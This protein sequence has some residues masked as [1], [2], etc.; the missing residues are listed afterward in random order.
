MAIKIQC[1]TESDNAAFFGDD[2]D[3]QHQLPAP[4]YDEPKARTG[5]P[6]VVIDN[7][8]V[9]AWLI[10]TGCLS[11]TQLVEAY[12]WADDVFTGLSRATSGSIGAGLP[13]SKAYLFAALYGTND[14]FSRNTAK[15]YTAITCRSPSPRYLRHVNSVLQ[16]T[17]VSLAKVLKDRG[18]F[19][20]W[21]YN[22]KC[23]S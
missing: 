9:R 21:D 23:L 2:S 7:R 14:I 13:V 4:T 11:Y 5:K 12:P 20:W 10:E 19:T 3:H 1:Y 8:A 15:S 22:D 18:D 17:A 16:A 6:P